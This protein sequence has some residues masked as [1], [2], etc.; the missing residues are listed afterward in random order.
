MRVHG[1]TNGALRSTKQLRIIQLCMYLR[2][3]NT[4][5]T[6]QL[7]TLII[8]IASSPSSKTIILTL[9]CS[10]TYY[11]HCTVYCTLVQ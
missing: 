5:I 4:V 8:S 11:I 7:V 3:N 6:L 2:L 9:R 1:S 10:Y